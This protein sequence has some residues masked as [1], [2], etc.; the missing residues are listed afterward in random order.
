MASFE[1]WMG[2]LYLA[3]ASGGLCALQHGSVG[4]PLPVPLCP[5]PLAAEAAAQHYVGWFCPVSL[6]LRGAP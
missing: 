5:V 2:A 4:W 1:T 3:Q 6:G